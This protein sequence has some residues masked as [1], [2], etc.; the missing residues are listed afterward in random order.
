M[1]TN[2]STAFL[3]DLGDRSLSY[4]G[5]DWGRRILAK[6]IRS[7]EAK[8]QRDLVSEAFQSPSVQIISMPAYNT[9]EYHFSQPQQERFNVA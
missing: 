7:T 3:A 9:L 4:Y 2:V 5:L 8:G 1:R 6:G